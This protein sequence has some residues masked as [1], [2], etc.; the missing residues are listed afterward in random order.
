MSRRV[1]RH[2]EVPRRALPMVNSILLGHG[3][4]YL[5]NPPV[6]LPTMVSLT[7]KMPLNDSSKP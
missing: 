3:K 5:A 6:P 7:G 2:I 1:P 4:T